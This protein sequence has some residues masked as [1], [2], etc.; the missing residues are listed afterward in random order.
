MDIHYFA[1]QYP[2]TLLLVTSSRF[3]YGK[4]PCLSLYQR[5]LVYYWH[6]SHSRSSIDLGSVSASQGIAFPPGLIISSGMGT[7]PNQSQWDSMRLLL[8]LLF[9]SLEVNP[10]GGKT[11]TGVNIMS[12]QGKTILKMGPIIDLGGREREREVF[13]DSKHIW[14]WIFFSYRANMFSSCLSHIM[15]R[16][17][18]LV[19]PK[20]S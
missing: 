2:F 16:F 15:L 17:L 8:G 10:R 5:Q 19:T 6:Q 3:F 20:A 13:I 14:T 11:E 4:S 12:P 1:D 9:S 18:F 7:Q